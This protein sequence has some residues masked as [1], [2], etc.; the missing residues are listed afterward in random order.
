[1]LSSEESEDYPQANSLFPESSS[2]KADLHLTVSVI[3]KKIIKMKEVIFQPKTFTISSKG[4]FFSLRTPP[5]GL[6]KIGRQQTNESGFWVNDLILSPS[7]TSVS[8]FHCMIDYKDYL[9]GI[10]RSSKLS[11][12]MGSHK[13]LGQN[14]LIRLLP[15]DLLR[16]ILEFFGKASQPKLIDL[17]SVFGTFVSVGQR[18]PVL[19]KADMRFLLGF[20]QLIKIKSIQNTRRGKV[21]VSE[22]STDEQSLGIMDLPSITVALVD[23]AGDEQEMYKFIAEDSF[24]EILIGRSKSCDIQL[25]EMTISRVQ[26]RILLKDDCWVLVDGLEYSGTS[27]G[28]WHC[29]SRENQRMREYSEPFPLKPGTKIR[30]SEAILQIDYLI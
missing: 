23:S 14:S 24:K 21:L 12:L 16:Y 9:K 20:S 18:D 29:I 22:S 25:K 26:C 28:T 3:S 7:D 17:G 27:N 8:R 2:P 13:R 15:S 30:L 10:S 4:V 19:L 6:F 11:F 5:D 1:M